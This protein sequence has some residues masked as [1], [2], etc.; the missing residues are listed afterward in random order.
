MDIKEK[1]DKYIDIT[2]K[3]L[4]KVRIAKNPSISQ[5]AAKEILKMAK[6]Y[7]QDALHF[8]EKGDYLNALASIS[9]AHGW[10]DTAAYIGLFDVE[11]SNLFTI[12]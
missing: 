3:A 11:D 6:R 12:D 4:G 7:H 2:E 1:L 5:D 8:K 10:L 9:Y